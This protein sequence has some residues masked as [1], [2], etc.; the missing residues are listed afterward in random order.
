MISL[1]EDIQNRLDAGALLLNS[2]NEGAGMGERC[3]TDYSLYSSER[4][5]GPRSPRIALERGVPVNDVCS[6][7]N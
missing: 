7:G 3:W 1:L 2:T 6:L 5:R 4:T